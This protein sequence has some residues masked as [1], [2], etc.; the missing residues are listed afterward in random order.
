MF[1]YVYREKRPVG[2]KKYY[3][4]RLHYIIRNI[5]AREIDKHVVTIE[6]MC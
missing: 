6:K 4:K 1:I 5:T 3:I 2:W